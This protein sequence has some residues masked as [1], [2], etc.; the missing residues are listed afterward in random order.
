MA[1]R[2]ATLA[3]LKQWTQRK[4]REISG[5]EASLMQRNREGRLDHPTLKLEL[6]KLATA[7]STVRQMYQYA[8]AGELI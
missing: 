2:P 1:T 7:K 8:E 5:Q 6:A 4:V 3:E